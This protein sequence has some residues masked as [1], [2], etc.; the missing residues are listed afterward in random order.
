MKPQVNNINFLGT[1][2]YQCIRKTN[3]TKVKIDE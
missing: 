2:G 3:A 1:D